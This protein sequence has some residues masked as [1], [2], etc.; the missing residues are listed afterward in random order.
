M[1][2]QRLALRSSGSARFTAAQARIITAALELFTRHG[3]GGTSLQMIADEVGVTKAAVYHQF[4][5]KDGI[6]RAVA[7]AEID[8]LES[9]L[10]AAEAAPS[11][12]EA[13]DRTIDGIIDLAIERRREVSVLLNDPIIG[14]LYTRDAHLLDI[15]R[16]LRRLLIGE[17]PDPE[18]D[19]AVAMLVAAISGTVM[20][21]LVTNRNKARMRA[22]LIHLAR[23]FLD[24][25]DGST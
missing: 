18:A 8:R 24:L 10:D 11:P 13:R 2:P 7:E 19:L 20:H 23:R 12:G 17:R 4:N 25:P 16:R 22:Q 21:P 5:S 6:V 9:V 15:L 14:R 3:V 1:S